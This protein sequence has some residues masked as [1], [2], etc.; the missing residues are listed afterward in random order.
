[1]DKATALYNTTDKYIQQLVQY[2]YFSIVMLMLSVS[3]GAL[4]GPTSSDLMKTVFKNTFF[5]IIFF[6]FIGLGNRMTLPMALGISASFILGMNI[7]AGRPILESYSNYKKE[8]KNEGGLTMLNPQVALEYGCMDMTLRDLE[9]AFDNDKL[10]LQNTLK[11]AYKEL[12]RQMT[13]KTSK[14]RLHYLAYAVGLPY[15]V[16]VNDENA[17]YIATILIQWGFNFNTKC[18]PQAIG[19]LLTK[20]E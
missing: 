8:Y 17:P 18:G 1:M 4:I 3:Y 20:S 2:K 12:L 9:E 13:D 15:N 6:T 19:S 7:L 5:K 16:V 14:E 10:K 11:F